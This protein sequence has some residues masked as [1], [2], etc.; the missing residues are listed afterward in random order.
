MIALHRLTPAAFVIATGISA[1]LA[2][3]A[4]A[5]CKLNGKYRACEGVQGFGRTP[6][7]SGS[8]LDIH[9]IDGQV[10]TI[11]WLSPN[12]APGQPIL[13]NGTNR[14][15]L[16]YNRDIRPG[17]VA[18]RKD[19]APAADQAAI[20]NVAGLLAFSGGGGLIQTTDG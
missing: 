16:L 18:A 19:D 6:L 11:K 7:T 3:P 9:W 14:G 4:F 13:I 12:K 2:S 8:D 17:A 10:T 1:L 5:S 15:V 20:T